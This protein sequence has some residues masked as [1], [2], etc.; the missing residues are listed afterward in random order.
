M[1]NIN[2]ILAAFTQDGMP[3]GVLKEGAYLLAVLAVA[4]AT[5]WLLGRQ[6]KTESV[7]FGEKVVD[8]L[9]FPLLALLLAYF[10]QV[11][12]IK[13][14]TLVLFKL[15]VPVLLALVLIRLCAR[16][17]MAVFPTSPVA[18]L[19]ERLISWLA[20]GFAVLWIT[21]LLPLVVII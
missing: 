2:S 6:I 20:W 4:W 9:M 8:G 14:Q 1:E 10:A 19:T 12:L 17:L 7:L 5:A 11:W 3:A 13:Q 18:A 21:D 16:V 15:A